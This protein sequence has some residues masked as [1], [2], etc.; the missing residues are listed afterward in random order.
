M[1]YAKVSLS[2]EFPRFNGLQQIKC[3]RWALS[4]S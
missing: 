4:V 2:E 1:S 3:L